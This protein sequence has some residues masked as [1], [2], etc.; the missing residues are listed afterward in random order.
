LLEPIPLQH[1]VALLELAFRLHQLLQ[2]QLVNAEVLELRKRLLER[3]DDDP[4]SNLAGRC[5][6][7]AFVKPRDQQ[8]NDDADQ[9]DAYLTSCNVELGRQVLAALMQCNDIAS[10]MPECVD[11]LLRVSCS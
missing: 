1:A 2:L 6:E 10:S 8:N 9:D 11:Y 5:G 4:R 7:K 3:P